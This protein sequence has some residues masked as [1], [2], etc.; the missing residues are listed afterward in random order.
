MQPKVASYFRRG[1]TMSRNARI[2]HKKN[3][4]PIT[5]WIKILGIDKETIKKMLVY[6]GIHH[7]GL[8]AK[9][10]QFY[11][12]PNFDNEKELSRFYEVF[13]SMPV[14][15]RKFIKYIAAHFQ[16]KVRRPCFNSIKHKGEVHSSYIRLDELFQDN[17]M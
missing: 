10:T 8:Y 17:R 16:E 6:V 11:R 3:E 7:T 13:H 12:L 9:R 2:S 5:Q 15:K 4:H 14:T 1:F